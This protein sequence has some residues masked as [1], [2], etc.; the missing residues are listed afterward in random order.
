FVGEGPEREALETLVRERGLHDRVRFLGALPRESLPD[1]YASA[2]AFLFPSLTETQGLVQVEALAAGLP[3]LAADLPQNRDVLGGCARLLAPNAGSFALAME[4][5]VLAVATREEML[6]VARR[7]DART[8]AVRCI[9]LY[10]EA[11]ARLAT[12]A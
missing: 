1:Y 6:V 11:I 10:H 9:E 2:D 3:V 5:A 7:F 8:L 4:G 12:P